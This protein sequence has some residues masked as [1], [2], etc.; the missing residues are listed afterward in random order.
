MLEEI[1]KLYRN[2]E[3]IPFIIL[4]L[5]FVGWII[6]I[7]R[8]IVLQFIYRIDFNKFNLS[9]RKMLAAGDFERA[10]SLCLASGKSGLALIA[11]KTIDT[12]MSDAFKVRMTITEETMDFMPRIRRRITQI[13]NLATAGILLGALGTVHGIWTSFQ[14]A[15][16]LE[17]GVKSFAF[18]KELS[19]SLTPLYVSL[20]VAVSLMLPYG[21]LD[22]I[23]SRLEGEIEHS[24]TIIINILAPETHAIVSAQPVMSTTITNSSNI[25]NNNNTSNN[26]NTNE[27]IETNN[28][29]E[30]KHGVD[31]DVIAE[32]SEQI[33][34]EE[35]II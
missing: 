10:R 6:I 13:P 24:L 8:I 14:I 9:L 17:L 2:Q 11:T 34:D 12:Y 32:R 31:D 3:T 26:S 35:E 16:T 5:F 15:D 33:P 20:I 25:S 28:Q 30:D 1:F 7:E 19:H 29:T 21:F 23:A 22:A 4:A 27:H 18:T